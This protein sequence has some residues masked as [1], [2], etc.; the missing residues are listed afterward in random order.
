MYPFHTAYMCLAATT[1]K[2]GF[3]EI[4]NTPEGQPTW[5]Q[6][7]QD[8]G[9]LW[10]HGHEPGNHVLRKRSQIHERHTYTYIS[11]RRP[12]SDA[13]CPRLS[14]SCSA[15][16]PHVPFLGNSRLSV[17]ALLDPPSQGAISIRQLFAGLRKIR[18]GS[19]VTVFLPAVIKRC[20]PWR[21]ATGRRL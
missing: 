2:N 18:S 15:F 20:E 14:V 6:L 17:C 8:S 19:C 12:N 9:G 5:S 7:V 4:S 21:S 11:D 10:K 13:A 1:Q 3:N 16:A